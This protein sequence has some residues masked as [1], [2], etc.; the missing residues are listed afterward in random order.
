MN[1]NSSLEEHISHHAAAIDD[2]SKEM[3]RQWDTIRRLEAKLD[4][5]IDHLKAMQEEADSAPPASNPPP[6]Y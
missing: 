2:I 6:H 4:R 5:I 1:K 3:A